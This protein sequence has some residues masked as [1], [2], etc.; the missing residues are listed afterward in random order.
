M[1]LVESPHALGGKP[2]CNWWEAPQ[3]VFF[4]PNLGG[5]TPQKTRC[6]IYAFLE[7]NTDPCEQ[8]HLFDQSVVPICD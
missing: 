5:K 3:V 8:L 6:F 7:L 1:H 4:R 2:T